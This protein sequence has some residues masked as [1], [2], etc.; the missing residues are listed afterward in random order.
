MLRGLKEGRGQNPS[1]VG[2]LESHQAT[3]SLQ[4]SL[5]A[6]QSLHSSSKI[7]EVLLK[8]FVLFCSFLFLLPYIERGI[9]MVSTWALQSGGQ[10]KNLTSTAHR[11]CD[12]V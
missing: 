7:S 1:P 11:L 9:Q 4:N 3:H 6:C 8:V 5:Q 10:K 12:L 2:L